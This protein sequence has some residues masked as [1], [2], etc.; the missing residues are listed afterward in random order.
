MIAPALI[1]AAALRAEPSP[2]PSASPS[3]REGRYRTGW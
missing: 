1:L 3:P 2:S